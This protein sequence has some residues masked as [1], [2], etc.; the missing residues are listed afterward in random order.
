MLSQYFW[1]SLFIARAPIY[2]LYVTALAWLDALHASLQRYPFFCDPSQSGEWGMEKEFQHCAWLL[3][4][5]LCKLAFSAWWSQ[6]GHVSTSVMNLGQDFPGNWPSLSCDQK[7]VDFFSR[8]S[9]SI[10]CETSEGWNTI[11]S[12]NADGPSR[13]QKCAAAVQLGGIHNRCYWSW[14]SM[15]SFASYQYCS[16]Q[17]SC[18]VVHRLAWQTFAQ[19][20]SNM[21]PYSSKAGRARFS[22]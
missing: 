15:G 1:V 12:Y 2:W 9:S 14:R 21:L 8:I 11:R 18:V 22:K 4:V 13:R 10:K 3:Y 17:I 7:K 16:M 19:L 20:I 6:S 5:N